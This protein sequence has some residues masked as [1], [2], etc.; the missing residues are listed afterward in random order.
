M[1]GAPV[2]RYFISFLKHWWIYYKINDLF[3]KC[4]S[5]GE[6]TLLNS[7]SNISSKNTSDNL[8]SKNTSDNLWKL[9]PFISSELQNTQT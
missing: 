2:L 4:Y 9:L 3:Y 5:F 1:D 8:T 7:C 6:G